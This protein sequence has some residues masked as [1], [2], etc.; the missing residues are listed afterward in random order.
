MGDLR[1]ATRAASFESGTASSTA[2]MGGRTVAIPTPQS[3]PN[4]LRFDAVLYLIWVA[5]W[6]PHAAR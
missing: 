1:V 2:G 5:S 4:T 3:P 6:S